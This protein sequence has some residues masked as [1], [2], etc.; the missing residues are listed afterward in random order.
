MVVL[1]PPLTITDPELDEVVDI[2]GAAV[3]EGLATAR[4]VVS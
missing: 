2:V 3:E 4:E 1:A